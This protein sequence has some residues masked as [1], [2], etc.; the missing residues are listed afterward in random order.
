MPEL[1]LPVLNQVLLSGRL[2]ADPHPLKAKDETPGAAFTLASNRYIPQTKKQVTTFVDVVVWGDT[3][4]AVTTNLAKGSPVIV[5][6]ALAQYQKRNG[7]TEVKVLQVSASTV[8]FLAVRPKDD[9]PSSP[10]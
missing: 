3:A 9:E 1:K 6:G 4:V 2:V 8:Q 5:S 7:K 10:S